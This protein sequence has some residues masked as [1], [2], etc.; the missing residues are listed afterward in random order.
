MGQMRRTLF[1]TQVYDNQWNINPFGLRQKPFVKCPIRGLW[2]YKTLG[3]TFMLTINTI[4]RFF[5]MFDTTQTKG[6]H[7]PSVECQCFISLIPTLFWKHKV[8]SNMNSWHIQCILPPF[9]LHLTQLRKFQ[10]SKW[11]AFV[12]QGK[13]STEKKPHLTWSNFIQ[14]LTNVTTFTGHEWFQSKKKRKKIR[15]TEKQTTHPITA[16]LSVPLWPP[17]NY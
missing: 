12:F 7:F 13:C 15:Q 3:N 9:P 17:D 4:Y 10:F 5:G 11:T 6:Q 16:F 1:T 2:W 14:T 8:L